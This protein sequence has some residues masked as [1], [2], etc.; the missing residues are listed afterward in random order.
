MPNWNDPASIKAWLEKNKDNGRAESEAKAAAR[1]EKEQQAA[2]TPEILRPLV[3]GTQVRDSGPQWERYAD[4]PTGRRR[5]EPQTRQRQREPQQTTQDDRTRIG[6]IPWRREGMREELNVPVQRSSM[7]PGLPQLGGAPLDWVGAGDSPA[8]R[9]ADWQARQNRTDA[10]KELFPGYDNLLDWTYQYFDAP[11]RA[12]VT[13]PFIPAT[14]GDKRALGIPQNEDPR[15][16]FGELATYAGQTLNRTFNPF[17]PNKDMWDGA[18]NQADALDQLKKNYQFRTDINN[19][20]PEQRETAWRVWTANSQS[21]NAPQVYD[22]VVN[23]DKKIA[24]AQQNMA[25]AQAQGD[26]VA[27]A[28]WGQEVTR[29]QNQDERQILESNQNPWAEII[30]GLFVDPVDWA[31]GGATELL[32][33]TP[34]AVKA[35][36]AVQKYNISPEI[37]TKNISDVVT[38]SAPVVNK[39][40]QG[41]DAKNFWQNL[42]TPFARTAETKSYL[43]TRTLTETAVILATGIK[44]K[45]AMQGV[46]DDWLT[47][48]GK[49]LIENW[50][51]GAGVLGNKDVVKRYP[52][53]KAAEPAIRNMKSLQGDGAFDPAKFIPEFA[54]VIEDTANKAYGAGRESG[55]LMKAISFPSNFMRA[56]LVDG[57]L[58]LA[59]R[60]WIRQAASQTANVLG[61]DTYSL[62]PL[63]NIIA[64]VQKK[65]GGIAPDMRFQSDKVF[66]EAAA[67][68][69]AKHWTQYFGLSAQNPVAK[70]S[71][72]TGNIWQGDTTIGGVV[73][74]G[75]QAFYDKIYGTTFLR[76]FDGFWKDAVSQQF[77]PAVQ[78]LG[79]EPDFAKVLA[80]VA[81]EAGKTG[82][83]DDVRKA[84]TTA[85]SGAVVKDTSMLKIPDELIPLELRGAINNV[86][87]TYQ[88]QQ[89]QEAWGKIQGI[90]AQARKYP[91]QAIEGGPPTWR[92][93]FTKEGQLD[94]LALFTKNLTQLAQKGGMAKKEAGQSALNL[95]RN[96]LKMEDDG[97]GAFL[98]DLAQAGDPK[99]MDYALDVWQRIYDLKTQARQAVDTV[100]GQAIKAAN[101][102]GNNQA[103]RTAAWQE[104]YKATA[105]SWQ[106]Y[107]AKFQGIIDEGRQTLLKAN[108]GQPFPPGKNWN[109]V[110]E[111]YFQYDDA[112]VKA[113]QALDPGGSWDGALAAVR[114]ANRAQIDH[115]A[116]ELFDVLRRFPTTDSLDIIAGVM[117][118]ADSMGAQ[119]AGMV[120]KAVEEAKGSKDWE[121]FYAY[122][123]HMWQELA[124]DS[125]E[126]FAAAKRGIVW[127]WLAD[128]VPTKLRWTDDFAGDFQLV[129]PLDGS[130]GTWIVRDGNGQLAQLLE[131]GSKDAAKAPGAAADMLNGP[132]NPRLVSGTVAQK[133]P[134]GGAGV[135]VPRRVIDDYNTLVKGNLED[136]VDDVLDDIAPLADPD[137]VAQG[138]QQ[139]ADLTRAADEVAQTAQEAAP[140]VDNVAP[141]A[142]TITPQVTQATPYKSASYVWD[143][144]GTW[145]GWKLHLNTAGNAD[146]AEEISTF[147]KSQNVRHKVGRSSGQDG[148]DITVYVGGRDAA[149]DIAKLLDAQMGPKLKPA[150]A[151]VL[152]D[153]IQLAGNVW[154]RFDAGKGSDFAQYG[155]QGIPFLHVDQNNLTFGKGDSTS[156]YQNALDTLTKLYGEYFTGT[157]AAPA[158]QEVAQTVTPAVTT[159]IADVRKA[160]AGVGIGTDKSDAWLWNSVKKN[161]EDMGLAEKP[162][163]LKSMTPEE[164]AK[165]ADYY[166]KRV[167]LINRSQWDNPITAA[168]EARQM[169]QMVEDSKAEI[170]DLIRLAS[171]QA[172]VT[173]AS[174]KKM[175]GNKVAN[176]LNWARKQADLG[177]ATWM[178]EFDESLQRFSPKATLAD[179]LRQYDDLLAREPALKA[180]VKDSEQFITR[181]VGKEGAK[182]F[183]KRVDEIIKMLGPE[184]VKALGL[185]EDEL[186]TIDRRTLLKVYESYLDKSGPAV[187]DF[188]DQYRSNYFAGGLGAVRAWPDWMVPRPLRKGMWKPTG[189]AFSFTPD[190][191]AYES[192]KNG[193]RQA[194]MA[195]KSMPELGDVA[196]E[197]LK[198]IDQLEKYLQQNLPGILAGAPN[199]LTPQMQLQVLDVVNKNLIPV[200]DNVTAAA[201]QHGRKMGEF[202]MMDFNDRRNFDTALAMVLPFH[203]YFTRS[204]GNWLQRVASKP[205]L[206]DVYLETQGAIAAENQRTQV[207]DG[208][209]IPMPDRLQG[210]VPN[211]LKEVVDASWMPDRLQNPL[212]W[213]LP[214]AMYAPSSFTEDIESEDQTQQIQN[215][216][217]QY[218]A[219][220]AFPWYQAPMYAWMDQNIPVAEGQKP[221]LQQWTESQQ[222]GD[223]FPLLRTGAYGLQAAGVTG[224]PGPAEWAGAAG[225]FFN[226]GTEFDP[227]FQGRVTRNEVAQG[228][229]TQER[230]QYANQY[231]LNQQRGDAPDNLIPAA[232]LEQAKTDAAQMAQATGVERFGREFGGWAT[233]MTNQYYPEG[234][235]QYQA[236][237][238]AYRNAGYGPANLG[239][240]KAAKDA[241]LDQN[242]ELPV[243][244]GI[245]SLI[246]GAEG[247]RPPGASQQI[248]T[249]YD[250]AESL[251]AKAKAEADAAVDAAIKANP[252]IKN[253]EM[254]AIRKE[255]TDKYQPQIDAAY[256]TANTL[257]D[258]FPLPGSST[259]TTFPGGMNPAEN[260]QAQVD[261][262]YKDAF[263]LQRPGEGASKAETD[264]FY[265]NRD[266][267]VVDGLVAMGYSEEEAKKMWQDRLSQ[268]QTTLEKAQRL[269][270]ADLYEKSAQ[271][272]ADRRFYVTNAYGEDAAKVWDAYLDLPKGSAARQ[273][274]KDAHP[275]LNAF[276]LAA[277]E[278]E[279]YAYL[280][281]R[282]G[283]N[284]VM[285]WALTPKWTENKEDQDRRSAYLD[286]KPG[287]W[288]VD[289]WVDGRPKPYD[290][291]AASAERNYGTDWATAEEMFGTDIWD[292]VL[293]Y[294]TATGQERYNVRDSLELKPFLDWWYSLLPKSQQAS[295]GLRPA[296]AYRGGGG[297]AFSG[298]G[299]GGGGGY[300]GGSGSGGSGW[301][302]YIPEVDPRYMDRNLEVLPQYINKWRP[303]VSPGDMPDWLFAGDRLKPSRT[304]WR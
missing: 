179:L 155:K 161:W 206:L 14:P 56:V 236:A 269:H 296:S 242:P 55:A 26:E 116:T 297:R 304:S 226:L 182:V 208:Q 46:I 302:Q 292:K 202:A 265:D 67:A 239:G 127:N 256:A 51:V 41:E 137:K 170:V 183:P 272:W 63:S 171:D 214:F 156:A 247:G 303:S 175:G 25:A 31:T 254:T 1:I 57:Y 2:R 92:P 30:F 52:L 290:P 81:V 18:E 45:P 215:Q 178:R 267:Q 224:A 276:N 210:T 258:Q 152:T 141:A 54:K 192:I 266:K 131:E 71:R 291:T 65:T 32:G 177:D 200:W 90:L 133:A 157:K 262:V 188:A 38:N 240:S 126:A 252:N 166:T 203:Y 48:G 293:Q 115:A 277:F 28:R 255:V 50:Q 83:K 212:N 205:A 3:S 164:L 230:A 237:S 199:T 201:S 35:V 209:T 244:W 6:N 234:E 96:I 287:A 117:R 78:A 86:I 75:E 130:P 280:S 246:P 124:Q 4:S 12:A 114:D 13:T 121:S 173:S 213:T 27:A 108:Q 227:Y 289:A 143:G 74:V 283:A 102:A 301:R 111:R 11:G 198:G 19:L 162:K 73:P 122:R 274:Y 180:T 34:K 97:Y 218:L 40:L 235:K 245:S 299:G 146:D 288:M 151:D 87:Q 59:P 139:G 136:V 84:V 270:N 286:S 42:V 194:R 268:N 68:T 93:E 20:P 220:K 106:D 125:V 89:A 279:G 23:K 95:A 231:L 103:A 159:T 184:T 190:G 174:V 259:A 60:N 271:D 197:Q 135:Y 211:P 22:E 222:I 167:D 33:L 168:D 105:A 253:S 257:S 37:A 221:R 165:A 113:A 91:E 187:E 118:Q 273:A 249:S 284:A 163:N 191:D 7:L 195:K 275:E 189:N 145:E 251:R 10:N 120:R 229:L 149:Q 295:T 128:Q 158:A 80:N 62:R 79:I 85:I 119:V 43:D 47:T 169:L 232:A 94:D 9:Y 76:S 294:R 248:T 142:E 107:A 243:G 138:I 300:G 29:L 53:L 44:D 281:Q 241:L 15:F 154:G 150:G 110:L 216:V 88:P 70:L 204:A 77:M 49:N 147:L 61:D 112:A 109:D 144:K 5:Q 298:G 217:L 99:A 228:N 21:N 186:A 64:D 17:N 261:Q 196:L 148:K 225:G 104:A 24:D 185:T 101:A 123:N 219:E 72:A 193:I 278:P 160:A 176:W 181:G 8:A 39:I 264:A 285:D 282:Y 58:N 129:G 36:K 233:G 263:A 172:L 153:D 140:V 207:V 66:T 98:G 223:Y 82:S 100:N 134:S 260:K 238:Q 250:T 69:Q 132:K 16:S